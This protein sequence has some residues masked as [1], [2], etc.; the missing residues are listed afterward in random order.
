MWEARRMT[1]GSQLLLTME[2]DVS[3][4]KDFCFGCC[5]VLLLSVAYHLGATTAGAQS[6]PKTAVLDRVVA[7]SVVIVDASGKTR[8]ELGTSTGQPSLALLDSEGHPR[9]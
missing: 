3:K 8:A 5:G 2:G 9:A 7:R 1:S 6:G 4:A